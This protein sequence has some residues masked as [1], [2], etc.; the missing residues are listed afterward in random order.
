MSKIVRLESQWVAGD[1][2]PNENEVVL[3]C[4]ACGTKYY[5]PADNVDADKDAIYVC[6]DTGCVEKA[7]KLVAAVAEA[8]AKAETAI[9]S[10]DD[11]NRA[12]GR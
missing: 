5:V 3:E 12:L 8:T 9:N 2:Q 1:R 6:D 10:L 4:R 11:V 7:E